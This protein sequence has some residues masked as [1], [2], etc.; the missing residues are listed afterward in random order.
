MPD[1]APLPWPLV[2]SRT[3]RTPRT[4]ANSIRPAISIATRHIVVVDRDRADQ[5][6]DESTV[7][8]LIESTEGDRLQPLFLQRRPRASPAARRAPP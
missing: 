8:F 4:A 1:H 5:T 2:Y 7:S 6:S 3:V